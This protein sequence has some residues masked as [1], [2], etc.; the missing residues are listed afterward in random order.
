[1]AITPPIVRK[2]YNHQIQGVYGEFG[3]GSGLRAFYLQ[4]TFTPSELRR[5]SLISDISGSERWPVRDLFQRDVDNERVSEGL[6]PYLQDESKIKFF[7]PL[8]LTTLPMAPDGNS[9]RSEMLPVVESEI[10]QDQQN[11]ECLTRDGYYR[12]RWIKGHPEYAIL[13]WN[14]QRTRLVAIDG[15]H[16]L[17]ALKRFEHDPSSRSYRN[18]SKW[19]IPIV[20]VC[21]RSEETGPKAPRVLDVVRNIFVYINTEA[22][23]VNKARQIL[24]TDESVNCI[25]TQELLQ[26][27]HGNDILEPDEQNMKLL[28]LLFFDWR[29]EESRGQPVH[30]PAAVKNIEEIRDWFEYYVLGED[31]SYEQE[32]ALDINPAHELHTVFHENREAGTKALSHTASLRVRELAKQDLL[33]SVSY[34]LENFTPYR[35]YTEALRALEAEYSESSDLARHAFY[36]LRFG[37]NPAL[38]ANKDEVRRILDSLKNDIE[39]KK[40]FDELTRLEIG[41]RGVMFSFGEL[42]LAFRRPQWMEY[43]MWF[44]TALNRVYEGRWL[45][46]EARQRGQKHLLH[47]VKDHNDSVVN[48]RL[49]DMDDALGAYISLFVV[50]YG[51]PVPDEWAHDNGSFSEERL[52]RLEG[53]L[54]RGYKREVRRQLREQFPN[55]GKE[56]TAAVNKEATKLATRHIRRLE[57]ALRAVEESLE[58]GSAIARVVSAEGG[59]D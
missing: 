51:D 9:V 33:P 55:G 44:T 35:K 36:E 5:I 4:S 14:D 37:T 34:V 2:D 42:R 31:Y 29:G 59:E 24:L 38:E 58:G 17:S 57:K 47:I 48:Y 19:R 43:A 6:V 54:R 45:D 15:Q 8:T 41:L 56:L 18:F 30:A 16:R 3:A 32:L 46:L 52:E 7:N 20:V 13:E 10:D 25:C 50:A 11:W 40:R 1:M 28:P 21:F 12:M 39:E 53:T 27:S 23:V 26:R 49:G 22:K